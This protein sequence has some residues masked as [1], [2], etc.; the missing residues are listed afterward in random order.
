MSPASSLRLSSRGLRL[1]AP[2]GAAQRGVVL[3]VA[4][5]VLVV[6]A[7]TGLSMIRQSGSGLSIAGNLGIRQNALSGADLGTEAALAWWSTTLA[8]TPVVLDSD[9][10]GAGYFSDWG[11]TDARRITGDPTQYGDLWNSAAVEVTTD[12]GTKNRVRYIIERL[13]LQANTASTVAG[14]QCVQTPVT[15]GSD[16]SGACDNY[17]KSC[18]PPPMSVHYRVST[19]VDGPRSTVSY[20]Q[21]MLDAT[22]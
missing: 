14:Q 8:A 17:P 19:R 15:D 7:L 9:N 22:S 20:I 1:H 16:K 11:S 5:I 21:V 12:D 4:L 6:M 2:R 10:T 18:P 13:C 3:F